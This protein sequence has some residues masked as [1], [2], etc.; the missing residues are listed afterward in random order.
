MDFDLID[1]PIVLDA[2]QE[3]V[4]R[5]APLLVII[6]PAGLG[7]TAVT[8]AKMREATGTFFM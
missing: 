4:R 8:L 2:A 7:K 5:Y 6:G 3:A 1:K